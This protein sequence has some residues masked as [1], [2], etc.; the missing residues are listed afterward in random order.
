MPKPK[1]TQVIRHEI[2][3]GRKEKEMVDAAMSAY[4]FNRV[5][6]PVVQL[7]N[8]PFGLAAFLTIVASLGLTGVGFVFLISDDLS[9]AAIIDAFFTQREQA[10]LAAGAEAGLFGWLGMT[11]FIQE[12]LG[13][14][15][16][17]PNPFIGHPLRPFV[18]GFDLATD[19]AERAVQE[20]RDN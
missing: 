18:E 1:P 6:T 16:G 5:S 10:L 9:V 15:S 11:D 19:I 4:S 12:L 17:G 13:L 2:V 8:D 14:P 20:A 3:L 7:L